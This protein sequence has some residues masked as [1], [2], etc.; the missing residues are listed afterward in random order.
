MKT[1][2]AYCPFCATALEQREGH[3]QCPVGATFFAPAVEGWIRDAVAEAGG[4]RQYTDAAQL[5]NSGFFCP[6]CTRPLS[7]ATGAM[8]CSRCG[9]CMSLRLHHLLVEHHSHEPQHAH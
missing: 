5:G 8:M 9:L 6:S 3:L 2:T 1:P 7:Y 4:P